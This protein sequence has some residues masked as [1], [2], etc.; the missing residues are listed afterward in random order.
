MADLKLQAFD[1]ED[2]AVVSAQCQDAVVRVADLA[3][4][5][6]D[7]RF[8]LVCNR[9]DWTTAQPTSGAREY[10]RRRTG[11]RFEKVRRAQITG[12]DPTSSETVLSL[13]AVTF[14]A[15]ESP[16]G[17]ITLQFAAGAAVRLDV[18][19]IEVEL[20]DLGAVWSTGHKP[21]HAEP[22]T[23]ESARASAQAGVLEKPS[24]RR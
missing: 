21:D 15:D 9:F 17:H 14:R 2:L 10:E 23:T 8:V 16:A 1:K 7:A 19:Y 5:A 3:F 6:K 22:R 4:R 13:L 12:F 11:L 24:D 18:D 20:K